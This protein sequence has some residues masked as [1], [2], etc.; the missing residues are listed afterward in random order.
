[1]IAGLVERK[2]F[3]TVI[4]HARVD[5]PMNVRVVGPGEHRFYV[6]AAIGIIVVV[7]AGFSV[8]FDLLFDLGSLSSLVRWHGAI[9]FSW[10][11]LFLVQTLLV[12]RRRVDLHRRLGIFGILLA[13]LVVAMA[14]ATLIVA[15]RLGGN[16]LPPQVPP[17][18]FLA[19]GLFDLLAFTILVSGAVVLRRR[20]DFHKRL[21]L[22]AS[23]ILLDAALARFIA[24]Y[25]SWQIDAGVLRNLLM[26]LCV[27]VDTVRHRRL[28]PAFVAGGLLLLVV[29]D[30]ATWIAA[31]QTWQQFAE[32]IVH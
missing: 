6:S 13:T 22:L 31:T 17:P 30:V 2:D 7:L 1:M 3:A 8:Q 5:F 32:W 18:L 15:C 11:A 9:M 29:D 4:K 27:A 16:H 26:G 14:A 21:M 23:L 24:G 20:S 12:A 25:T 28:H 10:I 19:L